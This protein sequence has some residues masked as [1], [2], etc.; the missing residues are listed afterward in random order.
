MSVDVSEIK[1]YIEHSGFK[2][3]AVAEKS[4]LDEYKLCMSLQGKR[5]LEAGEYANI[6]SALGVPM[7]MFVKPKIPVQKGDDIGDKALSDKI[8]REWQTVR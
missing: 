2:Q 5:K 8:H 7:T 6:C 1:L 3:K 4:G